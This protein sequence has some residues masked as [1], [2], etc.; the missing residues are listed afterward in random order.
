MADS[1]SA[2]HDSPTL[3]LA[4]LF[5]ARRTGDRCLERLMLD[6]LSAMGIRVQFANTLERPRRRKAVSRG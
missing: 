6:R 1:Q 5:A 2:L 4:T 3:L